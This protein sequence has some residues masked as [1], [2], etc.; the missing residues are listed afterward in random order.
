MRHVSRE[1]KHTQFTHFNTVNKIYPHTRGPTKLATPEYNFIIV[2]HAKV[3]HLKLCQV[4]TYLSRLVQ[5]HIFAYIPSGLE[6]A[7]K[8]FSQLFKCH[9]QDTIVPLTDTIL[10]KKKLNQS[11]STKL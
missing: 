6:N 10:A 11:R 1:D 3:A 4:Q 7:C 8:T 9:T 2:R 5:I